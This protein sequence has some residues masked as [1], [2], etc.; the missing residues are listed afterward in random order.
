MICDMLYHGVHAKK[1]VEKLHH[2]VVWRHLYLCTVYNIS[3]ICTPT[4]ALNDKRQSGRSHI[5]C[6]IECSLDL[7]LFFFVHSDLD[8]VGFVL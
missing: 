2:I 3:V 5:Q 8:T 7:F 4:V 6:P 1:A